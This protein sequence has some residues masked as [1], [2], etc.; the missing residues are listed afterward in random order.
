MHL[1]VTGGAGFIG[2]NFVRQVRHKH[3]I[4]VIDK[5][6]YCA[7]LRNVPSNVRFVKCDVRDASTLQELFD[8]FRPEVVIHF[9]AQTHVDNSF[10]NSLEFTGNNIEGT[11][12]LLEVARAYGNLKKFIHVSTDEVYGESSYELDTSNTECGSILQPTNPYAATKA[13]AEMLV[14]AYGR[15]YGLP[16]IITRGNNVYGEA[17]YPEKVIPKFIKLVMSDQKLP[18]HGNGLGTRSYLHVSDAVDAFDAILERGVVGEIYN[19]GTTQER[20]TL[21]VAEDIC[22]HFNLDPS[23]SIEFVDDR[24]FNDR[25]YYIDSE[26]LHNLGWTPK[27]SW[28]DGLRETIEWYK[29][30]DLDNYWKPAPVFLVYGKNGWIGGLLGKILEQRGYIYHFADDRLEHCERDIDKYKPTHILNAAGITGR[31]NVDWCE[32][33]K[34][35]VIRTNVAAT[36][37]MI[38]TAK[39]LGIH[40]TNFATG[41]IYTYDKNHPIGGPGFTEDDSPNFMGS[42]YSRTKC[43][44]E[45]LI[46][47]YDNVWQL[48]LRMPIS[49]DLDNPRNFVYKIARYERVVDIPNSMTV[50]DEL[51]PLAIE[52]AVRGLTGIYNFTNPG[53]V[54]HREVLEMYKPGHP[55]KYFTEEEQSKV[56]IAPRSN[57]FLDTTKLEK[58]FPGIKNI[59]DSLREYVFL[60]GYTS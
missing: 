39:R 6:D 30:H 52:G 50:L 20:T 18:I 10:G 51:L 17:Q 14:M 38:D 48:R 40:V 2:S 49:S 53:V 60:S 4:V 55:W 29:T 54:S 26:K 19:I 28:D 37:H 33:H 45:E 15:S 43:M 31:P 41:C 25:R 59:K 3:D 11:H 21:S 58:A 32:S 1:L 8:T 36:L 42:Y 47:Q 57:N 13:A 22:R 35:D 27:K 7:S 34:T 23:S 24:P 56:L 5:L 12:V 9:A 46:R 44:V 16:F